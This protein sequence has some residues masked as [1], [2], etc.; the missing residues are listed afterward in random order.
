MENIEINQPKTLRRMRTI[1]QA[2][3]EIKALDPNSAITYNY[4]ST[5]CKEN[6]IHNINIGTKKLLD[7]NSL[8]NY[9]EK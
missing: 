4:I 9:L 5:L 6:K 8:L 7:L 3:L 2:L 1:N